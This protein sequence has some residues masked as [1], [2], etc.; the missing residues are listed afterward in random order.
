MMMIPSDSVR[1]SANCAQL[2][3]TQRAQLRP[4]L[5]ARLESL[6]GETDEHGTGDGEFSHQFVPLLLR[7]RPRRRGQ[8]I[9]T[10]SLFHL[11]GGVGSSE[12][13]SKLCIQPFHEE[14]VL[15]HEG[16]VHA[17]QKDVDQ[18][19]PPIYSSTVESGD[20]TDDRRAVKAAIPS[21]RLPIQRER[22]SGEDHRGADDDENIKHSASDNGTDAD[23][24]ISSTV[25]QRHGARRELRRRRSSRHKRRP[26]DVVA[27][28]QDFANFL[29]RP[30]EEIVAHDGDTDE[31]IKHTDK[32][33]ENTTRKFPIF[34]WF[35]RGRAQER[36]PD[37]E[38]RRL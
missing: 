10:D 20:D 23:G 21:E 22:L 11:H 13:M 5:D 26:G 35:T 14:G 37:S 32:V 29:E 28:T 4:P 7:L 24:V 3:R 36:S 34:R 9:A 8:F 17:I 18:A 1:V 30:D 27:Q 6:R 16:Y 33:Q 31:Q 25:Y 38:T 15:P 19:L 2:A 12:T